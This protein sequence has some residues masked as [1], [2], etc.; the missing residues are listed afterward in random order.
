MQMDKDQII[1]FLKET[2]K[3]LLR[4][5]KPGLYVKRWLALILLGTTFLGVGGA[6]W[7]LDFYRTTPNNWVAALLRILSLAFLPRI[8]RVL[9]FIAIG[10]GLIIAGIYGLNRSLLRPYTTSSGSIVGKLESFRL[11]ERGPRIVVIGGGHGLSN[12]L[13]G[14]KKYSSNI[15]AVV[16]VADD[17]GSSGKLR[18][19]LGIL[20]PGDIRNCLAALSD[21]EGLV[22][23]LFQYRFATDDESL[24]GHSFGN[25]FLSALTQITGSFEKAVDESARVL[26]VNGQVLPASLTDIQLIADKELP[27]W[28]R[29]VRIRGESIIPKMSGNVKRVWLEPNNPPA[30]PKVIQA[31]LTAD[32]IVIGPGSLYTSILPNLLI[33]DITAAI[34]VSNA[35]KLYVCNLVTQAGE[36]D[37]Y[38]VEDHIKA[39]EDHS[40]KRLF[41]LTICNNNFEGEIPA[42]LSWVKRNGQLDGRYDFYATNLNHPQFPGQHDPNKTAKAIMDLYQERTGPLIL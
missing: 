34:K 6:Y 11:K 29:E 40:S 22:R 38:A 15:T 8:L 18:D 32:I 31:I 9:I 17:G 30:H 39:I 3:N 16:T 25:L 36:T 5:F 2:I 7:L 35:L 42:N 4:W 33:Q 19:S 37:N 41:N 23:E 12:I 14:L 26:S 24:K 28:R 20:P 10:L 1:E 13:S 27:G 21:D